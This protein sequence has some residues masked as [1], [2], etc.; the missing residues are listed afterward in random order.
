MNIQLRNIKPLIGELAYNN[1][2][3][4]GSKPGILYGLPKIH[5]ED[6]PLRPIVSSIGTFNYNLAKFLVPIISP[7]TFNEHTI[8][9]STKFV[10][11]LI[12]S[13]LPHNFTMAS[14]DVESLFNRYTGTC[15]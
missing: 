15:K 7:L 12:A 9:N 6:N 5:K 10:N 11:E 2:Y 4:S 8:D 14:F 13:N 3:V 1:I